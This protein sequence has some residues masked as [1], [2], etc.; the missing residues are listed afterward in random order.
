LVGNQK[1]FK[2]IKYGKY[3]DWKSEKFKKI[4]YGRR[5]CGIG[6]QGVVGIIVN[7]LKYFDWK[8]EKS[9]KIKY[10]RYFDWNSEK[11][12]KIKYGR[13]PCGIGR[14]GVVG[15]TVNQLKYFYWKSEKSNIEDVLVV[16]EGRM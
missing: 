16:L 10:G 14:L 5:P 11:F 13:R 4:K 6:R 12:K 1:K 3:F 2:K 7:Q 8:S 9:K 15:I